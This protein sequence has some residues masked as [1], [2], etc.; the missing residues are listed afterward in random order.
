MTGNEIKERRKAIGL[1]Q[2]DLSD[3]IGYKYQAQL[4][5]F[6][7]KGDRT[8]SP[9]YSS[10]IEKALSIFER[11][12]NGLSPVDKLEP[13]VSDEVLRIFA[14]AKTRKC[15]NG[16]YE[17]FIFGISY[18]LIYRTGGNRADYA[19][20]ISSHDGVYGTREAAVLAVCLSQV[21]VI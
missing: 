15:A 7:Q 12:Y 21:G 5:H 13:D 14:A 9:F 18:G 16:S 1:L 19:W 20:L 6:E 11:K 17:V 2:R 10:L 8:I 4:W 3:K